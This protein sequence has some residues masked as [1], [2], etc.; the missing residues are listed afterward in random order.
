MKFLIKFINLKVK[1]FILF[2]K[3]KQSNYFFFFRFPKIQN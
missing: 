2:K 1:K 3:K